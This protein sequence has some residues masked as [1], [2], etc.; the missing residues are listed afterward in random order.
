MTLPTSGPISIGMVA[1]ELGIGLPLSLGDSRVRA[2]A[3]IP[4]GP[5]SLGDLRGKTAGGGGGGGGGSPLSAVGTSDTESMAGNTTGNQYSG[6]AFPSVEASGGT[7]NYA[8]Q[9]SVTTGSGYTVIDSITATP[10][11]RHTI[12]RF[13]F[14]DT[15]VLACVVS[16]GVS[17][18]TVTNILA[19]Y[20]A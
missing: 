18:V 2:L 6:A 9:W 8:Y 14:S 7:G 5:I 4:S 1:A 11:V 19:V 17:T 10:T 15:C 13:G 3:G 16:D 12:G 20:S